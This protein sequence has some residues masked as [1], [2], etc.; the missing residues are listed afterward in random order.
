MQKTLQ[1]YHNRLAK[2][3]RVKPRKKLLITPLDDDG[4]PF[5]M[6]NFQWQTGTPIPPDDGSYL[7]P[8]TSSDDANEEK[9][10][11]EGVEVKVSNPCRAT[12]SWMIP[13]LGKELQMPKRVKRTR[14]KATA[15][16][17]EV[18]DLLDSLGVN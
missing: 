1:A 6:T 10:V 12:V 15:S 9:S 14:T 13:V 5:R 16:V 18:T 3:H 11:V 8:H 2:D 17:D 7:L 4:A